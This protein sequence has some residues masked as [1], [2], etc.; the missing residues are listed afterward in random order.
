[1]ANK[2]NWNN[3]GSNPFVGSVE[4]A[5]QSYKFP[6]KVVDSLA[7]K[8]KQ[9]DYTSEALITKDGVISNGYAFS[10]RDMHWGNNQKC[11]GNVNRDNWSANHKEKAK[12]FCEGNH[13]VII[14]EVCNNIAKITYF[15]KVPEWHNK[16]PTP[17]PE[18]SSMVLFGI[19]LV[20]LFIIRKLV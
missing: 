19:A 8:I 18:P 7:E 17:M 11:I 6:K 10:L 16:K 2:C 1:M 14:P 12:I 4:L 13:C 20:L 15:E 3:P 9:N 5:L